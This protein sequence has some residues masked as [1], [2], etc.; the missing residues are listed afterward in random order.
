MDFTADD[1]HHQVKEFMRVVKPVFLAKLGKYTHK[2]I[3]DHWYFHSLAFSSYDLGYVFG[4]NIGFFRPVFDETEVYIGMN[5]TIRTDGKEPGL[6]YRFLSFFRNS[7]K[8][9][10]NLPET[11]YNNPE[12]GDSGIILPR[13]MKLADCNPDSQMTDF[14]L[15]CINSF[16]KIYPEIIENPAGLFDN[17]VRAAPDWKEFITVYCDEMLAHE[18]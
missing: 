4:I 15:D 13:Y 7:L 5:M 9:W 17:I 2:R 14:F 3:S 16:Q 8:N 18:S 10:I 1:D 11:T 12:R 6:R